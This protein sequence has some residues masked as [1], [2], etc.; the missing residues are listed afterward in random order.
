MDLLYFNFLF[1]A[2]E[3][4][5]ADIGYGSSNFI[6]S[7]E[8][9]ESFYMGFEIGLK[10]KLKSGQFEKILIKESNVSKSPM[11]RKRRRVYWRKKVLNY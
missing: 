1:F 7:D 6:I 5:G 9:Q 4:L 8:V 3:S 2:I 10:Q 11:G